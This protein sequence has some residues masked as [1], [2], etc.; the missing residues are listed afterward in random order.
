MGHS[1]QNPYHYST[2]QYK[3]QPDNPLKKAAQWLLAL[4]EL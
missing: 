2:H 1:P 4:L 3:I